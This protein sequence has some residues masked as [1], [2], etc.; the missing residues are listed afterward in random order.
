MSTTVSGTREQAPDAAGE[1]KGSR[2]SAMTYEPVLWW[3]ERRGMDERRRQLLTQARGD[4]L[5]IGAGTG[6]NARH[7]PNALDRLVLAEPEPHMARRLERRVRRLGLDAEVVRASADAL[8]FPDA[9]FDTVVSTLVL[10]TV[11]D[12]DQALNEI[13]R[14]LR[15]GSTLLFLEHVRAEDDRLASWQDRLGGAWAS[16][17]DGCQCNRRTVDTLRRHGFS[18]GETTAARWRGMPPI[19]RPVVSGRARIP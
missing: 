13:R 10:C 3:G 6:L 11:V 18:I 4:V 14:V 5:E 17:A 9:T 7:Y 15:P 12:V 16:F 1:V 2:L 19:V 8:P